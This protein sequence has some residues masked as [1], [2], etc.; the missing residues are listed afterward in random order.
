VYLNDFDWFV[1]RE[2][3]CRGYL[4]YVDDLALFSDSKRELWDRKRAIIDRL[5]C[6]RLIINEGQNNVL[7]TRC[8]IPWLGFVV[9]PTHGLLKRRNA[10]NFTRRLARN[11]HQI[12]GSLAFRLCP[13]F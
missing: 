7:P 4:R 3:G 13:C 5:A 12:V 11:L 2:L 6:E 1:Q 9:Y 8:G 10:V